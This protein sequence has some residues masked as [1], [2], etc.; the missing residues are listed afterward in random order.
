MPES[1]SRSGMAPYRPAEMEKAQAG[2]ALLRAAHVST[3]LPSQLIAAGLSSQQA[4]LAHAAALPAQAGS[5]DRGRGGHL[6]AAGP[7]GTEQQPERRD[8]SPAGGSAL[9]RSRAAQD[10]PGCPEQLPLP[11]KAAGALRWQRRR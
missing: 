1:P 6:L 11:P 10:G 8:T 5:A 2:P 7:A 3:P 4:G 9:A